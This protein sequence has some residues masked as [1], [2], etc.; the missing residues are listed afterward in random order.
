[1]GNG[2]YPWGFRVVETAAMDADLGLPPPPFGEQPWLVVKQTG[3]CVDLNRVETFTF[4]VSVF[5]SNT[6]FSNLDA[7]ERQ[8][9]GLVDRSTL[10]GTGGSYA[11]R[12]AGTLLGDQVVPPWDAYVRTLRF[13]S[14][15]AG[16]IGG[17]GPDDPRARYLRAHMTD[18]LFCDPTTCVQTDPAVWVPTDDCPGIYVRPGGG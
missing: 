4:E 5:A 18:L 14:T 13:E 10:T 8:V 1:M 12:Y 3:T 9:V 11:L 2:T 6:S 15:G 16:T 17:S 7:L